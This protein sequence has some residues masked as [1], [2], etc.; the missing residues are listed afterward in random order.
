MKSILIPVEDHDA[1]P[2]VFEAA[3]LIARAFDS[4]VEGFAV[5]PLAESYVSVEPVSGLA[6][7]RAGEADGADQA[8]RQLESFMQTHGVPRAEQPQ[9]GY[10]YGWPQ[11]DA[12]DESLIGSRGRTFDLVVIGRPGPAPKNP[13]MRPLETVLFDS[14]RPVLIVPASIPQTLGQNVLV[15]WNGS[16]EQART[17][18]FAIPI[19]QLADNVTVLTVEGATTPGPSGEEAALHLR[20]NGIK[21]TA[22][23]VNPGAR[24]PGE[25]I[26]SHAA[27]LGCDLLVKG[28]YTQSRLR[29]IIFGGTTRHILANAT[30]PVLMAH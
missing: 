7:P 9:V 27:S 30:L 21:S 20:R 28:A 11:A 12:M 4:Y 15:A 16:T 18:A 1:M 14:G 25:V 10:S 19:L 8:R 22:L 2:A 29:Q 5:R 6:I 3:R 17:N 23:T 13:R 26:L 24:T